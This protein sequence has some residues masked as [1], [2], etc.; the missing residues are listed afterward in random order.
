MRLRRFTIL[1]RAFHLLLMLAFMLQTATGLGRMYIE[2]AWGRGLAAPFGGY[3][4]CLAW[5][6]FGGGALLALF[7]LHIV[8]LLGKFIA[9]GGKG[10]L[11]GPD[12]LLPRPKDLLQFFQ[13]TFWMLGLG[14]EPQFDRWSYWEKFDYWAVF[15]GMLII[16]VTGIML[17]DPV[18]TTVYIYGW[19]LN[20]ALWVHRIEA[21]LAIGHVF[22]IHFFIAHLRRRSFPMDRAMFEGSV[23]LAHAEQEKGAWIE[24]LKT[25]GKLD[26]SMAA[27]KPLP[28]RIVAYVV[29]YAVVISGVLL[30]VYGVLNAPFVTW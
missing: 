17:W 6:K 28:A 24:R 22:I 23:D 2:T 21:I 30:L 4:G 15:W 25:A 10:M 1:Q 3:E 16:G 9:A 8:Y 18:A 11:F 12:T 14:K 19:G 5:H 27:E 7:A 20:L 13:H 29:G 26:A